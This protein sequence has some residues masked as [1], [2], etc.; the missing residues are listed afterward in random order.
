MMYWFSI[1]KAIRDNEVRTY[2]LPNFYASTVEKEWSLD[3]NFY[4]FIR[5]KLQEVKSALYNLM[6][7]KSKYS[8]NGDFIL[9]TVNDI[10]WSSANKKGLILY[11]GEIFASWHNGC[12]GSGI[13]HQNLSKEIS[14]EYSK[15]VKDYAWPQLR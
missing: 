2:L 8:V 7:I 4:P 13:N 5:V 15:L 3:N 1:P 9:Y 14:K 6:T 12:F 11:K 10:E